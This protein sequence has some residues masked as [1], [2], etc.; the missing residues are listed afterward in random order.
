[1]ILSRLKSSIPAGFCKLN[2]RWSLNLPHMDKEV[3]ET[4]FT[5]NITEYFV[6]VQTVC[7]RPLLRKEGPGNEA[8][9]KVTFPYKK[10]EAWELGIHIVLVDQPPK[11][12]TLSQQR[13]YSVGLQ[14][15][16]NFPLQ[17]NIGKRTNPPRWSHS[18]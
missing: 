7:T 3:C 8:S 17:I 6:H 15:V 10:W 2:C 13:D 9:T 5:E 12:L 11:K 16:I 1:M 14:T 18:S 4:F